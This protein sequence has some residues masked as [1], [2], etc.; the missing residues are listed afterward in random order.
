MRFGSAHWEY[1]PNSQSQSLSCWFFVL[2]YR[3]DCLASPPLPWVALS[4]RRLRGW[5][6]LVRKALL[7]L[8]QMVLR[9]LF[10][11]LP[12]SR[13][14]PL[15]QLLCSHCWR[16]SSSLERWLG[17]PTYLPAFLHYLARLSTHRLRFSRIIR[18]NWERSWLF[19][20]GSPIPQRNCQLLA[21]CRSYPPSS[22][23][24]SLCVQTCP[25]FLLS[26][27]SWWC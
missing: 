12:S 2:W 9:S 10:L 8:S 3:I 1:F 19:L 24:H 16:R 7:S 15:P 20:L 14:S 11:G 23:V 26:G 22:Q 17:D 6:L 18:N 5:P 4:L 21:G 13:V 25:P 27:S